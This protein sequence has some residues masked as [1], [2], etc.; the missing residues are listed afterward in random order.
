MNGKK[1]SKLRVVCSVSDMAQK[2]ELSRAR[3]YQLLNEGVF[4]QPIYS[5]K[6]RRPFFDTRLQEICQEVRET[7]IGYNGE[8]ILFY[9]AR[10]IPSGN[11]R[12][13]TTS[14]NSRKSENNSQYQEIIETLNLMG[15]EAST[16][17]VQEAINK[18]YPDG[19]ENEDQGV[20]IREIFRFL[21]KRLSD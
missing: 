5:I 12:K 6:T 14:N 20:V 3:F 10:K 1:L 8:Y 4:P 13:N 2:L 9:S 15:L 11:T 19:M 7:G 17:N 18:L 21:K 16:S